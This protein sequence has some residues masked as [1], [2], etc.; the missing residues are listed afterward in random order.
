MARPVLGAVGMVARAQLRRRW[1]TL[2]AIGLLIGLAGAVVGSGAALTR[3]TATAYDRLERATLVPDLQITLAADPDLASRAAA[4]VPGVS[5]VWVTRALVARV[6]GLPAVSYIGALQGH[7][8]GSDPGA[9]TPVLVAG[10]FYDPDAQEAVLDERAAGRYGVHVGDLM[11]LRMLTQSDFNNFDTGFDEPGGPAVSVRITGLVRMAGVGLNQTPLLLAPA[12][13]AALPSVGMLVAIRLAPGPDA[14]ARADAALAQAAAVAGR[15]R[16]DPDAAEFP[17]LDVTHPATDSDPRVAAT[18]RVLVTGLVVFIVAVAITGVATGAAAFARHHDLRWTEQRIEAVLGLPPAGRVAARVLA[19]LPAALLA[20]LLAAAGPLLTAGLEPI[21]PLAAFE[22][23]PGYAPD[24]AVAVLSGLVAAA[25]V[26]LLAGWSARRADRVGAPARG[27]TVGVRGQGARSS[28][29]APGADGWVLG[30]G[31]RTAWLGP[32]PAWPGPAW[33]WVGVRFA[34]GSQV[35]PIVRRP[36]LFTAAAAVAT[37]VAAAT[38]GQGVTRLVNEPSRYGWSF[39]LYVQDVRPEIVTAL[40]A[41]PW[42]AAVTETAV[43][44]VRVGAG[45]SA[46]AAGTGPTASAELSAPSEPPSAPRTVPPDLTGVGTPMMPALA[47]PTSQRPATPEAP[48]AAAGSTLAGSGAATGLADCVQFP[49]Y[50][51]TAASGHVGWTMLAGRPVTRPDE[52]VVGTRAAS[53]LRVGVGDTVD[54]ASGPSDGGQPVRLTVVGIGLGPAI[55]GERLGANVLLDPRLLARVQQTAPTHEAFVRAADG[56]SASRLTADL[57]ARYEVGGREHPEEVANLG[58]IGGLPGLLQ[59]VLGL[60]AVGAVAH[61][62]LRGWRRRA[63]DVEVL[64]V[65]GATP[66]RIAGIAVTAA[67]VVALLAV[68]IGVPIGLGVGRLIWWEIAHAIGV[69]TDVAVP[70]TLLV[71]L[72][73]A[74][75]AL[76]ALAAAIPWSSRRRGTR[77]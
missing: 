26:G 16:R 15:D 19:A 59:L 10:R 8:V 73:V 34:V 39:D 75:V 36:A 32:G 53:T 31:R 68:A 40:R 51:I 5:G 17:I 25:L 56:V 66:P 7:P 60:L 54:V 30:G 58:G 2:V 62:V 57:G 71:G 20:G 13:A 46:G 33:L 41:D 3:R 18:R 21:G 42:I 49:A 23:R 67:A 65:L 9:Y 27:S 72:P 14:V 50:A 35:T 47:Q 12:A 48:P 70:T 63:A 29:G 74:A 11:P 38:V 22:P 64:R 61:T 55:S 45:C 6:E 37:L 1:V 28:G 24:T 76:A 43:S 52:V 77:G 4:V 44:T 69:G